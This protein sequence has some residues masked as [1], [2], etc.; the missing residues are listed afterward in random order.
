MNTSINV[1]NRELSAIK[2]IKEKTKQPKTNGKIYGALPK[3]KKLTPISGHLEV[4]DKIRV[5]NQLNKRLESNKKQKRQR[6]ITDIAKTSKQRDLLRTVLLKNNVNEQSIAETLLELKDNPDY[7]AKE[8]YIDRAVKYLGYNQ[9]ADNQVTNNLIIMPDSLVNKYKSDT[10]AE[11]IVG[12]SD[13]GD[14]DITIE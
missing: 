9:V 7:K 3:I 13:F 8:S 14:S 10:N 2:E 4:K 12:D 5:A 1:I 11:T 6:Y